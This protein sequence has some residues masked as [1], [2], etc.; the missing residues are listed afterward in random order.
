MNDLFEVECP[1]CGHTQDE[2]IDNTSHVCDE[3]DE[4]FHQEWGEE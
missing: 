3:C 2:D 4:V 1:A